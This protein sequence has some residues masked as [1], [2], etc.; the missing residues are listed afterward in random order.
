MQEEE[1]ARWQLRYDSDKIVWK[2]SKT[3]LK[4]IR[5]AWFGEWLLPEGAAINGLFMCSQYDAHLAPTRQIRLTRAI[6]RISAPLRRRQHRQVQV[7][8]DR[9]SCRL[10][11]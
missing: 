8:G 4:T 5:S 7:D 11:G 3:G 2:T 9:I 1:F 10:R 6:R